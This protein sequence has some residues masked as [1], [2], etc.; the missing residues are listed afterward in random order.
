MPRQQRTGG[1]FLY[2]FRP[3]PP[4]QRDGITLLAYVGLETLLRSAATGL[5]PK[6]GFDLLQLNA[7]MGGALLVATLWVVVATFTGVVGDFRYDRR[8][9]LLTWLLAAPA[10]AALRLA[11]FDGF[12]FVSPLFV[13]T[14]AATTLVLMLTIRFG[15]EQGYL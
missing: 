7:A 9:V 2:D 13:F 10:A 1:I 12:P 3:D 6:L 5:K 4:W 15:E 11:I 8:R 14:D